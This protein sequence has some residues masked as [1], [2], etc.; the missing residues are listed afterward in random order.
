M[1]HVL[2]EDG[3][4]HRDDK[5]VA[6]ANNRGLRYGD[7]L[8][9]TMKVNQ[10]EI[11]LFNWHMERL[12]SGLELLQFDCPA[13]FN[14]S[15]LKDKILQLTQR[16]GHTGL[17][18]IRLMVFRSNGGLY[19]S[20]SHYPHHVIQSWP[21]PAANHEFNENGLVLGFHRIGSK[22]MDK[23]SNAK[24]NNYLPYVLGALDAKKHKWNDAIVLNAAGRVA[25]CT[26]AN[27][28]IVKDGKLFTPA[29][30]EGPVLGVMR[31]HIISWCKSAGIPVIETC[32][33]EADLLV[34]DELFLTNSSYGIRWVGSLEETAY[35]NDFSIRLSR[36]AIQPL[37]AIT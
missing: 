18:R 31:R 36:E 12:F 2:F 5:L 10:G 7:G 33:T 13:Y 22:A 4:F 17:A 11:Q 19:D 16:N 30:E 35:K 21:L 14:T 32:L 6:G 37:F 28:F 20:V 34:A 29:A 24:T 26:I 8:F 15:Y 9:E 25:D 27:I 3:Q 1:S 23:L